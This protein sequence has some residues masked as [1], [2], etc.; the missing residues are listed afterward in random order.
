MFID[1]AYNFYMDS[2]G[3]D[4]DKYSPTLRKYHQILWS[5]ELPTGGRFEL[6]DTS[7]DKY[8]SY[9]TSEKHIDLSSDSIA[10]SYMNSQNKE[11][12]RIVERIDQ[13]IVESFRQLNG[14]IGGYLLFP[15]QRINGKMNINGSRGFSKVIADRFDLTLECIRLYYQEKSSPLYEVLARYKDF[16]QLFG[17]FN[18]YVDFFLLND[19]L[20]SNGSIKMFLEKKNV[21]VKSGY[22]ESQE[23]YLIYREKT[24]EFVYLRNLRIDKSLS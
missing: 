5:K 2:E 10:N 19:L 18:G 14:T 8:L 23:D 15:S 21:F 9:L 24:M 3:K 6:T 13:E 22:P 20:D 12:S 4:P 11:I 16:F 7:P 17:D 1:V